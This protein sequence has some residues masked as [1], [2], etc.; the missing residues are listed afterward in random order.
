MTSIPSEGDD[1]PT[2]QEE[3]IYRF[4]RMRQGKATIFFRGR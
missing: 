4:L 2:I 1:P 3:H